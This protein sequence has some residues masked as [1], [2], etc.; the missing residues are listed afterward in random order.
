[1]TPRCVLVC[2]WRRKLADRHLLPFPWTLSF[3]RRWCPPA[4]HHPAS[5][6]S[7]LAYLFLSTSLSFPL[8]GCAHGRPD[9]PW[10]H[11]SV[12]G[13]HGGGQVPSPLAGCVQ[14]GT[15]CRRWGTPTQRRLLG[16]RM[17]TCGFTFP[18]GAHN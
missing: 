18:T 1:M 6:L 7:L 10:F 4:S 15:P 11:C 17:S 3:H 16:P 9:W 14:V 12:L 5:F 8:G 13:P 2:S